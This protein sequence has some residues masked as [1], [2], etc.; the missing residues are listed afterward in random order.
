MTDTPTPSNPPFAA[1]LRKGRSKVA[2]VDPFFPETKKSGDD[3]EILHIDYDPHRL[4]TAVSQAIGAITPTMKLK[5]DGSNFA[6][7]EDDMAMLM[8]DFLDNPEYLTTK[9]GRTTYDEK[10]CRSILTHSVSNTIRKSIIRIRPCSAIYEYLKG[11]YHILTR[12]SQVNL[13]R[14]LLSIQM[15]PSESATALID[16]AM[17]KARNFKNLGGSFNED[18]LMGLIIQ[19]ATRSRPTIN[20]ALMGRLEVLLSTY[21]KT[22]SLGQVIGALEACTRQDEANTIQPTPTPTPPTMDFHHMNI[23]RELG[24]SDGDQ[25][26]MEDA[27]DPAAFRAII[28]GTCHLCKQPGHFAKN[29]PRDAKPNHA[30][31][32][33]NNQFQAYYPILAPSNMTPNTISTFPPNTVADRYRPRYQQPTVKARFVEM[34][35]EEPNID[36]LHADIGGMDAFTG[37]SVCDSGASHSLTGNLSA[38]YRYR[39][40]TKTIPLSVAT[41][42]TGRRSYVEGMGSLIF[43]GEDGRTVIV[44]GVF[45]SPDA[46]CTLIS[47]AAL[48]RAGATI[49]TDNNDIL[50]CDNSNLPILRARLCRSKLKWEMPP[51]IAKVMWPANRH[52]YDLTNV[53]LKASAGNSNLDE[54]TLFETKLDSNDHTTGNVKIADRHGLANIL[55][56][57]FGHIGNKRL[58]QLVRQRFGEEASK[59]ITRKSTTCQHCCIAKSTRHSILSSRDRIIEPMDI[60]TADLMGKF[61]D[62]VPYGGKYALTIRDIGSTYGE[63]HILTKKSDAT[64]VLLRAMTMWETKTGRRIKTFCSDNGGE[65][66]N[67][68]LEDWCHS[69]GTIHEKSLP[70]HHE[71][72]GSIERYNRT[73]ANMGRT[74]LHESGLPREFWGFAF[75]WA[76]RIQ[77]LIPNSLTKG[78]APVELLFQEK[79]CYDQMRLFGELAYIHIPHEKRRK[80]DDR[81]IEGHVVMYLGNSKG[82]LFYL[83]SSKSLTTSAWAEFP[84]SREACRAIRRWSVP[85]KPIPRECKN[86]MDISFVVN[87]TMLGDFKN[88]DTAE[89]QDR[90]AE[91]LN[92]TTMEVTTPKSYKQA[93]LST[94]NERWRRAVD[95]ELLNMRQMGVYDVCPLPPG[96]HVLGGGW[97]FV[98]K[99]ATKTTAIRYKARYVARGNGQMPDEYNRTFAPTASFS[100]L[101]ILLTMVSLRKWHVNSFDFVAAY[102]NADIDNEVWV[103]PPD[104]LNILKGFGCRLRKALY[105]TKQAGN[106]WW[107]CVADKL[108]TLGYTA[109]EFDRSV[110]IHSSRQAMIWLHVDDGI[111]AGKNVELINDV[112]HALEESFRLKWENGVSS[113]VGIDVHEV[114]GGYELEQCQLIDSITQKT[115]DG[116]PS[117]KTPLPAKCN[118]MT[119]ADTD[120]IVRQNEFIGTVGALSY[121][122]TGTRPDIAFAVNLLAR[123]AKRPGKEHWKSLQHLLGYV[124][125]TKTLRLCLRPRQR[126]AALN[127]W[128]DASWGGEFSRSTHGFLV[129]LSGCSI[130]WCAKRL[131]TVAASSCHA[132]YMALGLAARHGKWLKNLIDDISG[133]TVP[134]R[135]LCDNTSAIR[136]A[137]DSSSNKRTKHSDREYFITNQLL[138]EKV[139]TIEWVSSGD[140]SADIMTK[141]LGSVLHQRL[142]GQA[143]CGG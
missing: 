113:I 116:T 20:N 88:E 11:H 142:C 122:A 123:H 92:S 107:H 22:P 84:K 121:V 111:I 138:R 31:R 7:W 3:D 9:E 136:I 25:T 47:P 72:N 14:D 131:T 77:N 73:I 12:A 71:Q 87:R 83:P 109:S 103:R 13:W 96:K 32:G 114:S 28:K 117:T 1:P 59:E 48:I 120:D 29:C 82:W 74:L 125:H 91:A 55:H 143:L 134:L 17:S 127:V 30:M 78:A 118:L 6:E 90:T 40:L 5:V 63:C 38:L 124:S 100:S 8:D 141:P 67:S 137:E 36:V 140:M 19:Q 64:I 27:V 34:G 133:E 75:M 43:K 52:T 95:E 33:T 132:E 10:L 89:K 76:S 110:Y 46:A 106:C 45:Y 37:N 23:Q 108:L 135:L 130:S 102:L 44:N 66:C 128:S 80:L 126:S 58:K 104:G 61:D 26:F 139:A 21:K 42:R 35:S 129:Q 41:K 70:Y 16:R 56:S 94:D 62:A 15:E 2:M 81:A 85:W 115:W 60:V 79:P 69:R 97:V 18:H 86:K 101:R 50:I 99:P 93:M 105:G 24:G 4:R 98:K 54:L 65:F 53:S 119:L 112:K 39:K 51:Y 49:S 57:I 68:T